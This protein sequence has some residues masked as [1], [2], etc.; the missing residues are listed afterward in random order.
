MLEQ[1]GRQGI[2]VDE[3]L[4]TAESMFHDHVAGEK[5]CSGIVLDLSAP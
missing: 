4:H 2:Q 5:I 1:L 3:I